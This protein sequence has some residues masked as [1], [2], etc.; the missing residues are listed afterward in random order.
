MAGRIHCVG[1]VVSA[2]ALWMSAASGRDLTCFESADAVRRQY[3]GAWP[4]WTL[5][6]AGQGRTKCWYAS[7]RASSHDHSHLVAVGRN[8]MDAAKTVA[9]SVT[10]ELEAS[11]RTTP[12]VQSMSV[13]APLEG[14]PL[15]R[16]RM[17]A[18]TAEPAVTGSIVSDSVANAPIPK[19]DRLLTSDDMRRT[20]VKATTG[21]E[22]VRQLRVTA[23][24]ASAADEHLP[25]WKVLAI[26]V[27]AL[28]LSSVAARIVYRSSSKVLPI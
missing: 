13:A 27:F 21:L 8:K 3:P 12:P 10:E 1:V 20:N 18:M 15:S 23:A 24:S 14:A 9:P 6:A 4:S 25:G 22:P 11:H 16:A 28:A 19:A 2:L 26:F 7:T 5:R 17:N